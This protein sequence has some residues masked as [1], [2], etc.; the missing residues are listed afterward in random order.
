MNKKTMVIY[1]A[2]ATY[3]ARL[4][5]FLAKKEGNY[6]QVFSFSKEEDL[7]VACKGDNGL[8]PEILLVGESSI[9]DKLKELCVKHIF[10]LNETGLKKFPDYV[11]LNKYQ[12][13][14]VLF[15]QILLEYAKE[16]EEAIPRFYG[17]QRAKLVGV[18][19]PVSG[20]YQ[21]GFSLALAR[22]LG[23]KGRTLYINF[24]QYSGFSKLF[25]RGY[26]KD[27]SD[28]VYFFT[29]SKDKFLYWLEGVVERF[30]N[31][32]YIPPVIT[33]ASLAEVS[34]DVWCNLLEFLCNEAGYDY[35]VLD[36]SDSVQGIFQVLDMCHI[37]YSV[38]K[39]DPVSSAK[40]SQFREILKCRQYETLQE[41]IQ[42]LKLPRFGLKEHVFEDITQG[43]L[44]DYIKG[45]TETD[46]YERDVRSVAK[47]YLS[48]CDGT[49]GL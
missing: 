49:A 41:K 10:I 22:V 1:D 36:L 25:Q 17:N 37:I 45:L 28:L 20:C 5:Q 34:A 47:E 12:S 38:T 7:L 32:E 39:D 42:Y 2:D 4:Q 30:G 33:A 46:F 14:N 48:N 26:L 16:K 11:N 18:Y 3:A 9:C 21:T 6:F 8:T 19:T 27:L 43:D 23:K 35:I 24:E 13:A 44:Y 40:L 29:Y 31:M 15:Q